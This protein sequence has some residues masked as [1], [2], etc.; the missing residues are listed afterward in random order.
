MPDFRSSSLAEGSAS[1]PLTSNETKEDA[2]EPQTRPTVFEEVEFEFEFRIPDERVESVK[3]TLINHISDGFDYKR[4]I[5]YDVGRGVVRV[6]DWDK[7]GKISY[8]MTQGFKEV[9]IGRLIMSGCVIEDFYLDEGVREL[10]LGKET[11]EQLKQKLKDICPQLKA[12][13]V[14]P[15]NRA[16]WRKL[17][18]WMSSNPAFADTSTDHTGVYRRH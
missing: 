5:I 12:A 14:A 4:N 8:Y 9:P 15:D 16:F 2:N 18:V 13:R 17:G 6:I 3:N 7:A 1:R 10:G 11:I